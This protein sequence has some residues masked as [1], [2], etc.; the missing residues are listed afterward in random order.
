[1]KMRHLYTSDQNFGILSSQEQNEFISA[2]ENPHP[3][4]RTRSA[5]T[6]L[7]G[8]EDTVEITVFV[9]QARLPPG[10]R[11]VFPLNEFLASVGKEK[12]ASLGVVDLPHRT[13]LRTRV[14]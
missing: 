12:P 3:E 5:T 4:K 7:R 6:A 10:T 2:V 14:T 1:M 13:S 8:R 11:F 9:L